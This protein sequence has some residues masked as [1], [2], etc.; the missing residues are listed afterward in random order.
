VLALLMIKRM[1][2]GRRTNSFSPQQKINFERHA[3]DYIY[4]WFFVVVVVVGFFFT[5]KFRRVNL[6]DFPFFLS[7]WDI[8]Q[9]KRQ[10]PL[11]R[12]GSLLKNRHVRPVRYYYCTADDDTL[13]SLLGFV[14]LLQMSHSQNF[15]KIFPVKKCFSKLISS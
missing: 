15:N 13:K 8:F 9:K 3:V 10:P 6:L 5:L 14:D 11:S 2:T 1:M 4:V 7:S 12:H